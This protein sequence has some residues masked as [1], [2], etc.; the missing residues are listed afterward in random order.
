MAGWN[1]SMLCQQFWVWSGCSFGHSKCIYMIFLS[2]L[3]IY[4]LAIATSVSTTGVLFRVSRQSEREKIQKK[5][6]ITFLRYKL[7]LYI[8]AKWS[9]LLYWCGWNGWFFKLSSLWPLAWCFFCLGWFLAAPDEHFEKI[10]K[11]LQ[12]TAKTWFKQDTVGGG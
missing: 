6:M 5:R 2:D 12:V 10:Q 8:Q 4:R 3:F 1:I 9:N 11:T 7:V